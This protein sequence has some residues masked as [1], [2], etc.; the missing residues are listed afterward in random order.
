MLGIH[1]EKLAVCPSAPNCVS[2]DAADSKHR[3][4]PFRLLVP[5]EK[6]WR[7]VQT[8]AAALPGAKVATAESHYLHV[9]CRS[10]IFGFFDDLELHLRPQ[11]GIIAVRS[12]ARRGYFDFGVNRRRV[13]QLRSVL[14]ARGALEPLR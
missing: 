13:E 9:E 5:A 10:K 3:I 6:A 11:A 4:E 1:N 7:E 2:S 8:R 14:S 12:A